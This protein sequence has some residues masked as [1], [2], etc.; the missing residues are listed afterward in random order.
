M[1]IT[2]AQ[3][4]VI[5]NSVAWLV[6][7]VCEGSGTTSI[8][9]IADG[10]TLSYQ[11]QKYNSN[12]L[13]WDNVVNDPAPG[14]V[15]TGAT[16]QLLSI[17]NPDANDAGFYQ[18]V[19][20]NAACGS[21]TSNGSI[22]SVNPAPAAPIVNGGGTF[23]GS[24]N[25]TASNSGDGTIYFQG[26]ISGGTSFTSQSSSEVVTASGTYYFRTL[27]ASGCWGPEG[28]VTVIIN[29]T[30]PA[31]NAD[32]ICQ[33]GSALL[34]SSATCP[35]GFVN[36]GTTIS[37]AFNG[38]TDPVAL[39]IFNDRDNENTCSFTTSGSIRNYV[40]T[41]FQVSVTGNYVFTMNQNNSYDGDGYIVTGPFIPGNCSG[42]G[43]YLRGDND[44]GPDNEPQLGR[45]G[46]GDGAM[47]LSSGVTYTLIST[48]YNASQSNS[49]QTVTAP[50][51]WTVTPPSGGQIMLQGAGNIQ[52]YTAA[53]GGTAFA[54]GNSINPT[55]FYPASGLQNTSTPGTYTFYAACSTNPDCRTAV[56]LVIKPKPTVND[57]ADQIVCNNSSTTAIT[58]SSPVTNTV[59]NW[60]NDNPSIGLAANGTGDISTFTAINT[61]NAP[62]TATITVTPSVT[63]G[64]TCTGTPETFT[65]TVNPSPSI[66]GP[67]DIVTS[68]DP[69]LCTKVVTYSVTAAGTP[70]P[71]VS[72][73]FSGAT[74]GSGSGTGSGAIFEKGITTVVISADN[75]CSPAATTTFTITVNDT[76]SPT[77]TTP[78]AP[79]TISADAASCSSTLV[80]LFDNPPVF[81]DNC[82]IE[83]ISID[84]FALNGIFPV[85]NTSVIWTAT[86]GAGNSVQ[87]IVI[88]TVTD[89]EDPVLADPA[90]V[91]QTA[92]AGQCSAVI[93]LTAPL[94]T[95]NCGIAVAGVTATGIPA[96]NVFPVGTTTVTW[97]VTD[98]HGNI[99]TQTQDVTVTDNENPVLADPADV[100]QTA[101]AG[102]CSAVIVLTAPLATDNCGIAVAGVTASGIPAGNVF[103]VGTTTVTWSVTDIHGNLS[104][105]TQDVTVTD[106]E[107]PVLADPA[108]VNQTADAG[109]CSAVIVL[110]AP[111]ATD[112]CGI[113]VAGVT[114]SGIPAGNVFPVGT[115]TV[116]WSVTDIHGNLSTQTQDVTVTDN[117]N[118]VLA[119]PADV[120]QTADAGQCSAVIV[121]TAPAATDNCG[122]AVAGVTASGIPAG[123][124]FPVGT[125]TVT[126]SVT[127]I[128]GNLSTQTQDVTVTDNENPVLADPADVNQT[129]DAGLCSAVIVLTA[130]LATDNCGI[131]VA[132]VTSIG[133]PAGNVFPVGTTTVT[134]SVTDIHGNISTQTQ[135]VT[136]TDNENPV[137]AD[138]ADVNQTADAGQC[139]AVI[140]LT[141]PLATDNCAIA[142]AGVTA[143]GIPAGNV[144]PVGT[145]TVTWSVTDIHG[146]ISTQTQ[147]VTVTDNE[148]PV[149]ADPA[150]V[151]QTADAGQCSAVIVLTAPLATDNCGIAVAGVT[152]TGIPA[153]NVFPVGTTTVTWS[154]TDIHGNISTQTQDV[155]V[156]DNE[157]PVL[158]D[159][160]DVNQTADAGQCSAVI[161][162][163]APLATDNCAIAV[164][165]VTS[166]G[167]PAGNVFP[168]GTTT[169]TWSVTDIH[170]NISTQTQDVTVTDNEN[171]VLADPADVNQTADA[172][173]CSAVIVLTAPLATDNCGI[174]V[175][176][177]TATGIPAGNVFPVGT[178]TVTWSVTDIHGNISTQTQDVTVTD[179]QNPV[180]ADPADVNQTA[181]AGQCSAVIV[182]TTPLASD[183]CGTTP[184][185]VTSTGIPAG[186]VFP[187]GTTTVTWSVTDIHGNTSTQTQDVTVTDNENPVLA[188]PAD[189]NQTADA[190]QCSAVIVLTAPLQQPTT[191]ASQ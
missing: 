164:A 96:G 5:T 20:S 184:A 84:A 36:S 171:P 154:V 59:F 170:G 83:S 124:V 18:V 47:T 86:D 79:I 118:P 139:S 179:N 99:S 104:T 33:D 2:I 100:N 115:T 141:A 48:T 149:L 155:T 90:D 65:I 177:V 38:A 185:G 153:G 64:I 24:A 106:N 181:D 23:C 159:P 19:V 56:D 21:A 131:A 46:F 87:S 146:N 68:T 123:N 69:G 190:G 27:S 116:T 151:N 108:D 73:S 173:Q 101:D 125:T 67:G 105:Q 28:S 128:H 31:A 29:P 70:A 91:N 3:P 81:D 14:R 113:A 71:T 13:S 16:G 147:D 51:A 1:V 156:T 137:L 165:G 80:S 30:G 180:L 142:I 61:G 45:V 93:V 182:L 138:P 167:I 166:T 10:S 75:G 122:I 175:A 107:N 117:E 54:T 85:G 98:I 132:G 25:I 110:T 102:Q 172:G 176:G 129:A 187:V 63:D 39:R 8:E 12:T 168:V 157:N 148:N 7:P 94:A 77:V 112:N 92:D 143:T 163:T 58:F 178:T 74:S 191:A 89:D 109:Q 35:I 88:V 114:A 162:L 78:G 42:G 40:A 82:G 183:F 127:D 133:I 43:T 26:T 160:A 119:D 140:V 126:W 158:A 169:V 120:N 41:N 62:V 55:S 32:P 130:P 60:T 6:S 150:D 189:V 4:P 52:W 44:D 53:S 134:W 161:V 145:T 174:A 9:V 34:E 111:A 95:D 72:Y 57:P 103:P 152:A 188:D 66:T 136:V 37:G 50:F 17:S 121:L 49:T 135:D 97:S 144:F 22:L 11:W 186:N 76:E 15:V